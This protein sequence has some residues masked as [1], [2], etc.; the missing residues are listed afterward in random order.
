MN[1]NLKKLFVTLGIATLALTANVATTPVDSLAGT[2]TAITVSTD[3]IKEEHFSINAANGQTFANVAHLDINIE[4]GYYL[5]TSA[6]GK[7]P[8]WYG[9]GNKKNNDVDISTLTKSATVK[10][11]C[12]KYSKNAKTMAKRAASAKVYTYKFNVINTGVSVEMY[13]VSHYGNIAGT[14]IVVDSMNVYADGA[15]ITLGYP[16][17]ALMATL[18]NENGVYQEYLSYYK[19]KGKVCKGTALKTY[20]AT[21]KKYDKK[22]AK[23]ATQTLYYTL[24]GST[25][26]TESKKVAAGKFKTIEVTN[27]GLNTLKVMGAKEK[28]VYTYTFY[29]DTVTVTTVDVPEA[30]I[31]VG[32]ESG[33]VTPQ[34]ISIVGY[35]YFKTGVGFWLC[36]NKTMEYGGV[37]LN[38][39]ETMEVP[40]DYFEGKEIISRNHWG[41]TVVE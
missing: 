29:V 40:H 1:L 21:T 6:N 23:L 16:G 19:A 14:E 3:T 34:N 15:T 11:K 37:D 28:K 25:P 8:Q 30:N 41:A 27:P 22:Y 36:D 9:I 26:T 18:K 24:D 38:P 33:M 4:D 39:G 20:K 7:D 12:I 13:P 5:V 31:Y 2:E 10:V 35:K 32:S 17:K